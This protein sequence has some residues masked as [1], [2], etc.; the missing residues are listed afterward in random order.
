MRMRRRI[1]QARAGS[2][3]GGGHDGGEFAGFLQE[4]S[5]QL[6][7]DDGGFCEE[8]NPVDAFIGLFFAN[9]DFCQKVSLAFSKA[10]GA[11]VGADGG[12]AAEE[13]LAEY[14]G[15]CALG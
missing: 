10:G 1:E 4:R 5:E 2:A 13:L 15:L 8:F 3:S 14:G 11:V 12:A 7:L 6:R 9:L